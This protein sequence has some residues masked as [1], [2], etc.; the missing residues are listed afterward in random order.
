GGG[1]AIH[2]LLHQVENRPGRKALER[3]QRLGSGMLAH[4]GDLFHVALQLDLVDQVIRRLDH[5]VMALE[6][7]RYKPGNTQTGDYSAKGSVLGENLAVAEHGLATKCC[8]GTRT[9]WP[10]LAG[11]EVVAQAD[12]GQINVRLTG[13]VFITHVLITLELR[14]Q[15]KL[16]RKSIRR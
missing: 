16:R 12:G 14:N 10:G 2:V 11:L 8:G 13:A 9:G 3:Q 4:V 6:S 7:A 5:G 15:F 1:G